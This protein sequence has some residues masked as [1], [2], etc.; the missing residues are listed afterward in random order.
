MLEYTS[1]CIKHVY[2]ATMLVYISF[3]CNQLL[4]IH[5]L[6]VFRSNEQHPLTVH[7]ICYK[8][9]ILFY[10]GHVVCLLFS[11]YVRNYV[12]VC[13][14]FFLSTCVMLLLDSSVSTYGCLWYFLP[15][16]YNIQ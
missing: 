14:C 5:V 9:G 12:R 10:P 16:T 3:T 6:S 13:L 15:Q 4:V 7:L 11:L 8:Y 1:T 2:T